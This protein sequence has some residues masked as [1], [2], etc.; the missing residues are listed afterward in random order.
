MTRVKF[1]VVTR[2]RKA[3]Q[4][5]QRGALERRRQT[6]ASSVEKRQPTSHPAFARVYM[7]RGVEPDVLETLM[8]YIEV[9]GHRQIVFKSDQ[10]NPV[11]AVQRELR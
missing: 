4:P 5:S 9:S 11:K 1:N 7:R 10:K 2:W 3:E 6:T 8:E